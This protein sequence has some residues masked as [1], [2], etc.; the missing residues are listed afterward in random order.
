MCVDLDLARFVNG[1]EVVFEETH[2]ESVTRKGSSGT[3]ESLLT[4]RCTDLVHDHS[5]VIPHCQEILQ[6]MYIIVFPVAMT[7]CKL[8]VFV[9]YF[10]CEHSLDLNVSFET[11][12]ALSREDVDRE[13]H[14][15]SLH[16]GHLQRRP[17]FVSN[18]C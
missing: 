7:S 2:L 10:R 16:G 17:C 11:G 8:K 3:N 1:V 6:T 14:G 18:G 15:T 13:R 4:F 5:L 9:I 12:A